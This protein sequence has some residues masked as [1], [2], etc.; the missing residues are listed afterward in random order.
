M[1][2]SKHWRELRKGDEDC[3]VLAVDFGPGTSG[4]NFTQFLSRLN[5]RATV[6]RTI[7]PSVSKASA[8]LTHD[9]YVAG[10]LLDLESW[11]PHVSAILAY[12]AGA[13]FVASLSE[14][15]LFCPSEGPAVLLIDPGEVTG[16]LL[17]AR[18]GA[19]V[20]GLSK[21]LL[22]CEAVRARQAAE[23]VACEGPVDLPSTAMAL[24]ASYQALAHAAFR[25]EGYA[26]EVA[27][28]LCSRVRD[29]L[30]YLAAAGGGRPLTDMPHL[31]LAPADSSFT[32][33]SSAQTVRVPLSR[34]MILA[35]AAVAALV[36]R[37]LP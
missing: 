2:S 16:E 3:V 28:A 31:V 14:A 27:D 1:R 35:D 34:S 11:R 21:H 32:V 36:S 26:S 37:Y 6:F 22:P 25:R 20:D 30:F 33:T 8:P 19:A 29:Y 7:P 10:W 5:T 15:A 23:G 12:C 17:I 13:S 9:E 4:V 18:Y 24:S